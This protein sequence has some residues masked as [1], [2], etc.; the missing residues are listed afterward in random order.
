LLHA[1]HLIPLALSAHGRPHWRWPGTH[2]GPRQA[3]WASND[4]GFTARD[5]LTT[6]HFCHQ[7]L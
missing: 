3:S 6:P 5:H 2:C 1:L 4:Q 7:M